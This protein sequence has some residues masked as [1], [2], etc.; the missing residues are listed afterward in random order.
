MLGQINWMDFIFGGISSLSLTG[1]FLF[2]FRES[3][4]TWL[5]SLLQKD[6][7]QF[8][9]ILD[10]KT[11]TIKSD[12]H[13]EAYKAQ[14]ITNSV[15]SIYP[16]LMRKTEIAFGAVSS[17]CGLTYAI[18]F[19]QYNQ[20][21]FR[22]FMKEHGFLNGKIEELLDLIDDDEEKGVKAL[23][24]HLRETQKSAAR[25]L[26]E[27]AKNFRVINA[28]YCSDDVLKGFDE[29]FIEIWHSLV[30]LGLGSQDPSL[31]EKGFDSI[32]KKAPPIMEI[33][34]KKIRNALHGQST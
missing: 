21:D 32:T 11:E 26:C 14:L 16:E 33:F 24:R 18:D 27:D 1:L 5:R 7:A 13:R 3:L 15:H 31:W 19:S 23:E 4:K 34:R 9:Q 12:L 28:I 25:R 17:L 30:D 6:L 22:S 2:L 20:D 8:Q 10:I 29:C